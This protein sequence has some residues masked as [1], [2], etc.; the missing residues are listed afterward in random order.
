MKHPK[1]QQ[2][3]LPKQTETVLIQCT[4]RTPSMGVAR[5]TCGAHH[6]SLFRQ[7]CTFYFSRYTYL[8]VACALLASLPGLPG[9]E[10][11]KATIFSH[12][13]GASVVFLFRGGV[14][15][16][17]KDGSGLPHTV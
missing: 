12:V 16:A 2:I 3:G 5:W 9:W 6:V 17:S 14:G 13:G 15:V 10:M 11:I 4:M 8:K 1:L 7:R